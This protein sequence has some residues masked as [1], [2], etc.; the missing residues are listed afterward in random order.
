MI[1]HFT[2]RL[3]VQL[4]LLLTSLSMLAYAGEL[5]SGFAELR[6]A[7]GLDGTTVTYAPDGRVFVTQKKGLIN[8]IKNGVMLTV[9][10]LDLQANVDNRNERGLQSLVLDPDFATNGYI[11]VYY[12]RA[13]ESR[14]RVSR[15]T[16]N[17]DVAVA[18]SETV[19]VSLDPLPGSIHNGGGMFFKGGKLFI[20]T[21]DGSNSANAQSFSSLLG[22]VL[23]VN[24]DGTIPSDNP[25]YGTLSGNYRMIYA[26]GFRNPFRAAVQP[27]T[28]RVFINDVGGSLYEEVNELFPGKN[29]GWPVIEGPRT[30]QT[31]PANYQDPFYAYPHSQGCSIAG[32]AFYNPTTPAFPSKYT[33]KYFF[34]DYCGNY[35]KVLDPVTGQ[36]L[37]TFATNVN[38][39]ISFSIGNDGSFYYLARGGLAGGSNEANTQSCCSEV[40]RIQFTGTGEPTIS[41][42]P[43]SQT[44]PIGGDAVF[45]VGA[46]GDAPLSYQ[47]QRNN[48][49][50]PGA[51][52][53]RYD[54]TGATL[55]DNGAVFRAV[56]T[57]PLGTV[58]SSPAILTVTSNLPPQPVIELPGDGFKYIA[59]TVLNFSGSATDAEDGELPASALTWEINFHHAE[60]T[61]PALPPTSG[62]SG[63]TFELSENHDPAPDVWYRIYL[64]ATDSEGQ[65]TTVFREVF[66]ILSDVTLNTNTPG[67]KLLLDGTEITSPHSFSGVAGIHRSVEAPAQQTVNGIVYTFQGWSDGGARQ[68]DITTPS[69]NQT[70]VAYYLPVLIEA[71]SATMSGASVKWSSGGFTGTGYAD[72]S[73]VTGGYVEWTVFVAQAGE[74]QLRFRY[75]NG[76]NKD[77]PLAL[78]INN[79]VVQASLSFPPTGAWTNWSNVNVSHSFQAGM[80]T[81]RLTTIGSDGGNIDHLQILSST[82]ALPEVQTP[83]FT[84]APGAYSSGQ[85]V[86]ITTTT[87]GATIH[88]TTNNATPTEA[89]PVYTAPIV[90]TESRTIKAFAVKSGMTPSSV[91]TGQFT[92]PGPEPSVAAPVFSPPPGEYHETQ[93]ITLT[94][95]T[96]SALIYYTLNGS[97]PDSTSTLY[98]GPVSLSEATTIKA[99]AKKG[100]QSSTIVTGFFDVH[101][102]PDPE[103]GFNLILEAENA[104]ISGADVKMNYVGFTGAG[105]VD[106][107]SNSGAYIQWTAVVPSSGTYQLLFRYAN[108]ANRDRPLALAV[109]GVTTVPSLSFGPTGL[110]TDWATVGATVSLNAGTNTI[111]TTTIGSSGGN[112]DHLQILSS[113]PPLPVV[114][115]PVFTPAPGTY[116]S[117]QAVTITTTTPDAIIHYTTNN[118][119]PTV[120]SPVY[121]APIV[122]TESRTI[123]AFAVKS[124]MTS[125]SVITGQFNISGPEPSVAAPVFSPPPGEYHE[126]Q[127]VTLTTTTPSALIY[128]T[129]NGSDPDSTSTLYGGPISVSEATTIKAFAK[130]GVQSSTIVTGFFDVHTNPDPEPGFNVILEAENAS[131]SGADVKMNYVGFTGTGFVDY[132][133]NSGAYIQW[134]AV[135]PSAGSYQL[136]F[137]YA[138]GAN[139]D[140]PLALAINGVTIVPSLSFAPTG[141]WTDWATVGVTVPLNAGTNTIRTTT[142]GSSGGNLDHLQIFTEGP[143]TPTVS[144][145]VF[146][147]AAG[148]FASPINVTISTATPGSIIYYTVNGTT[149]TA[150]SLVYTSPVNIAEETTIRAI[151]MKADYNPSSVVSATYTFN[152]GVPP[153][154]VVY[155]AEN[156]S[157]SGAVVKFT[158]AG[159]TGSGFADYVNASNDYVQWNV[160]VPAGGEYI[161]QFRYSLT[162]GNRPLRISANGSTVAEGLS[163]PS[164]GSWSN[165]SYVNLPVTLNSGSNL[166]R[167]TAVGFSGGN[168]DHLRVVNSGS[169]AMASSA[170][171]GVMTLEELDLL[172]LSRETYLDDHDDESMPALDLY[173]IPVKDNLTIRSSEHVDLVRMTDVAGR[174]VYP[175]IVRNSEKEIELRVENVSRGMAVIMLKVGTRLVSKKVLLD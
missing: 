56:I 48:V 126:T 157:L 12:C 167:A 22:K 39:P 118:A 78:R 47:W 160:V 166:I 108:G 14:N 90:L 8:I 77:R 31:P 84:P 85:E 45:V 174:E 64:T 100:V 117:G 49:N 79:Q 103:P 13:G 15:F 98:Q 88:Y 81:I 62:I 74:H 171:S 53:F 135:V 42:Q 71:E 34:G 128:Y 111:R 73:V 51:T 63:G 156:A 140:R 36:V 123:K 165:W 149:P 107:A 75:G 28:E 43:N 119:T 131:I 19:I 175:G 93:L 16:A 109:N 55:A 132:A 38:R 114:A 80:N 150:A 173:P 67:L 61:H 44:V 154:D 120:D 32:G 142:I 168:V 3:K 1:A 113:T 139:R 147:P 134:T 122:L 11:Y 129:T 7:E 65:S 83:V 94:T 141:L 163:F 69:S 23:R 172:N 87:P 138:N 2:L 89:S 158:P 159:F 91:I 170:R 46:S 92:I 82:P 110:W 125:S 148:N 27:G 164:T 115:T 59:G 10:F 86:T 41:A 151:A 9:P 99:F 133:S 102:H 6:L 25:F 97:D 146:T 130:K 106:Y 60:H 40:W 70:L 50:I 121:T 30:T 152:E 105:F 162:S 4:V 101:T 153:F 124:G 20:T 145:P 57:N 21:G 112:L 66:P 116:S 33:G 104:S 127:L 26:L 161:L 95:T 136:L 54:F 35:I 72:F 143:T 68:H 76:S 5:P 18:G 17:G 96:P 58:V 52:S 169:V 144:N 137:R 155:E 29:Y 37:E 24:K